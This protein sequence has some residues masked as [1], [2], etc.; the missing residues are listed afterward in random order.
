MAYEERVRQFDKK[1]KLLLDKGGLNKQ[2]YENHRH[3]YALGYYKF[4][5]I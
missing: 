1:F 3:F 2:T 4:L 5:S